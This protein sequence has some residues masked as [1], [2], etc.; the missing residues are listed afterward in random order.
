M[1]APDHC[2]AAAGAYREFNKDITDNSKGL[3]IDAN[4]EELDKARK[5]L[6]NKVELTAAEKLSSEA[7]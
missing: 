2:L 6:I 4:I 3:F 1:K 7:V 5:I